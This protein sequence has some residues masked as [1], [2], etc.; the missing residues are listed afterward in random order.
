MTEYSEFNVVGVWGDGLIGARV[1]I[2]CD[3]QMPHIYMDV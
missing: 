2:V 1:E 3:A